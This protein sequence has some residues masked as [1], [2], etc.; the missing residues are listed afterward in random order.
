MLRES[1]LDTE[2][3]EIWMSICKIIAKRAGI[4]PERAKA[5]LDSEGFHAY[6]HTGIAEALEVV[7][8]AIGRRKKNPLETFPVPLLYRDSEE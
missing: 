6:G 8:A 5:I 2:D 4:S 7:V 1:T 3:D